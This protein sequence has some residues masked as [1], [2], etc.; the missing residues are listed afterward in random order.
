M[1]KQLKKVPKF[2]TEKEEAMF[3]SKA[4]STKYVDWSKAKPAVF[5]KLKPTSQTISLRIP[6]HIMARVKVQANKLDVPYQ[7]LMKQYI[8]E[9]VLKK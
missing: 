9:G 7:S 3:W 8:A 2:K 4:D 6:A 5:P 1:P